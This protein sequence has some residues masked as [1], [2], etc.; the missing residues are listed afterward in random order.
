MKCSIGARG[1]SGIVDLW[2]MTMMTRRSPKESI[3]LVA[4]ARDAV[5]LKASIETA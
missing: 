4:L 2:R 1:R 3:E 5:V